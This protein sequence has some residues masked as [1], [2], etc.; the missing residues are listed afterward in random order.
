M[1][2]EERRD[3]GGGQH[4]SASAATVNSSSELIWGGVKALGASGLRTVVG[5]AGD[6]VGVER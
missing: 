2:E 4:L 3:E 6:G 5:G 1:E